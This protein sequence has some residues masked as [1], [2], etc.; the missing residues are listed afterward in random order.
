MLEKSIEKI[1]L[2]IIFLVTIGLLTSGV[3]ASTIKTDEGCDT[4]DVKEEFVGLSPDGKDVLVKGVIVHHKD[5]EAKSKSNNGNSKQRGTATNPCSK[6]FSSWRTIPV[7]YVVNPT[8]SQ[9]LNLLFIQDAI[10]N[11]INEWDDHTSRNLVVDIYTVDT[12]AVW[13][14]QDWKNAIV[15]GNYPDAGVIAVTT[16]WR[17][18]RGGNIAEFDILMDEDFTWGDATIGPKEMDFQNIFTHEF[19]HGLGLSD[20]Y[21]SK[22]NTQTMFGYSWE[23]DIQKRTLE[24]GDIAGLQRLY[25]S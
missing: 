19:G 3:S 12:S 25:G 23:G 5:K 20:I 18:L 22:C 21:T 16:Y 24:S 17:Y 9:D 11:G 2:Y 14:V 6:T 8:N 7:S 4:N 1:K 13:G 10:V 15:F